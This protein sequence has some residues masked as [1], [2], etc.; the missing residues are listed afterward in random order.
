MRVIVDIYCVGSYHILRQSYV[1]SYG[2]RGE[3]EET[4]G[5]GGRVRMK[6]KREGRMT[7]FYLNIMMKQIILLEE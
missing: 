7:M 4:K 3:D 1:T 6:K 5:E 2:R